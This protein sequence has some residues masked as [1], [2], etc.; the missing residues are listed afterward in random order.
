MVGLGAGEAEGRKRLLGSQEM[1]E[2]CEVRDRSDCMDLEQGRSGCGPTFGCWCIL[3]SL[4]SPRL[5]FLSA[6]DFPLSVSTGPST[7]DGVGMQKKKSNSSFPLSLLP[8]HPG[9]LDSI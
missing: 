7:S 1:G 8:K 4:E 3:R 9:P 5:R 6:C 2:K